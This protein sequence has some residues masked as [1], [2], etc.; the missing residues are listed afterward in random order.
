M[1]EQLEGVRTPSRFVIDAE[2]FF[3]LL[4]PPQERQALMKKDKATS[5]PLP[6]RAW[7]LAK[8]RP[9][10]F[11]PNIDRF[12]HLSTKTSTSSRFISTDSAVFLPRHQPDLNA[13]RQSLPSVY[14][15]INQLSMFFDR[16]T[17][18][19]NSA[20]LRQTSLSQGASTSADKVS[21]D[22]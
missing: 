15:D 12:C 4:L 16:R 18:L 9:F 19:E 14:Q 2:A 22:N 1:Q 13:F 21:E 20:V 8:F 6:T 11:H 7:L 5:A 17:L 3:F 10:G